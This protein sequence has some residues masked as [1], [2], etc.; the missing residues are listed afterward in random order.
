VLPLE[1]TTDMQLH[2]SAWQEL[3]EYAAPRGIRMIVEN[4]GWMISQPDSVVRLIAA[5]DRN[6]AASPD[7]G[8]WPDNTTRY[9]GLAATFPLA[10]TCDYKARE[11]GPDGEH[12]E[13]DLKRCFDLG[14]DAG[15]RGPWCIEHANKD[16]KTLFR[17]LGMI[18]DMVRGWYANRSGA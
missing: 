14:W 3:A 12:P 9:A 1:E 6:L 13:Y 11:M 5:V 17:E 8:S 18:R 10:V 2:V 16:R 15:F 7:T 4:F